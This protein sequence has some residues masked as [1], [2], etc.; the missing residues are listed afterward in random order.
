MFGIGIGIGNA[1]GGLKG[2][3]AQDEIEMLSL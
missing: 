2:R 1:C 3:H